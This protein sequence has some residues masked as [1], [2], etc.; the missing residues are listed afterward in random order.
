MFIIQVLIYPRSRVLLPFLAP[1]SLSGWLCKI[2]HWLNSRCFP[3]FQ[4]SEIEHVGPFICF[5]E[6]SLCMS[7]GKPRM[8]FTTFVWVH[9]VKLPTPSAPSGPLGEGSL[10]LFHS[11]EVSLWALISWASQS[12]EAP[13][14]GGTLDYLWKQFWRI[15][16]WCKWHAHSVAC[17]RFWPQ[18]V[19]HELPI[20]LSP[21][22]SYL[23]IFNCCAL[24]FV[25]EESQWYEE[26][27]R[28]V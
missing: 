25:F 14:W 13:G 8:L 28:V 27:G 17:P 12:S 18:I 3:T 26:R 11:C 4:I 5:S 2:W 20:D 23:L 6:Q 16:P 21:S 19:N 22:P 9:G 15:S 10:F 24:F 7:G 1:G